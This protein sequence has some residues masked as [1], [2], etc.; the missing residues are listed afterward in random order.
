MGQT[1]YRSEAEGREENCEI[2][3]RLDVNFLSKFGGL[4]YKQDLISASS[5]V[6]TDKEG[7]EVT[8]DRFSVGPSISRQNTDDGRMEIEFDRGPCEYESHM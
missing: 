1:G 8:D 2:P 6:Y 7:N 5:L 4:Y 3:S